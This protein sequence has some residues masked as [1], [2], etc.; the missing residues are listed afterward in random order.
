MKMLRAS[1]TEIGGVVLALAA[2]LLCSR[3]FG[4]DIPLTIKGGDAKVVKVA[5]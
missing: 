3:A 2:L 4:D 1:R 5:K